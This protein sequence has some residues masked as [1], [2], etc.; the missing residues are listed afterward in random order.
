MKNI[1]ASLHTLTKQYTALLDNLPAG[2]LEA[3]P[4]PGKWNGKEIIGHLVDSAQTNIRRMV[5]SQY[6]DRPL[7][8]YRQDEWVKAGNYAGRDL[9]E[10]IQ[11]WF[12]LNSQMVA[13]LNTMSDADG[14]R[15]CRTPEPQTLRWLAQ[16]YIQHLLH[17][18]HQV[19]ELEPVSYP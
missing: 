19:L 16:D 1:A 17:H 4:A 12:L 11:L 9:H 8:V 6:E 2:S 10:I 7:I 18:L 14:D 15:Q 3:H 13:V 5:V